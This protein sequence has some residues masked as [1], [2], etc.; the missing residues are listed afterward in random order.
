M[1][2]SILEYLEASASRSPDKAAFTDERGDITYAALLSLARS[3]GT[4]L[5]KRI[6]ARSPVAV[7]MDARDARCV[8][9]FLGAVYAG[10]FY[11]PLDPAAPADR[12]RLFLQTL[13]PAAMVYDH[14][15]AG[16]AGGLMDAA[17]DIVSYD[18]LSEREA[19]PS[20]LEDARKRASVFDTLTVLFTSGSTGAPKCVAH[21]HLAMINYTEITNEVFGFTEDT[22][23]GNQSPFFYANSIIDIYPPLALGASV[24]LLPASA[25]S[26]PKRF[27]E[28]LN[29]SRVTELTMTPSSYVHIAN[30]GAL[31]AGALPRL[32]SVIMSGEAAPWRQV[33][34]WMDAAN[35]AVFYNF[36]GSTEALPVAVYRIDRDFS[37]DEAIPVGRLYD[38]VHILFLDENGGEAPMGEPG[39]IYVSSPW[40]STGYYRDKAR[41]DAAFVNDPL[42]RGCAERFYRTGDFGRVNARGELVV[43]GRMDAQIKHWGYRMELG[44]VERALRGLHGWNDG[45]CLFDRRSGL[46]YCFWDGKLTE[47]DIVSGLKVKLPKHMLPDRYIHLESVPYNANSKIDRSALR[48]RVTAP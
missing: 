37:D 38:R 13:K 6:E 29:S 31:A 33:R 21:N 39:E 32:R 12:L 35:H 2:T 24:N 17:G 43:L 40:L 8:P 42:G 23:F 44:E 41:S 4:A 22:V 10:G 46:V 11:A 15:Y 48:S 3:I 7:L 14:K 9:A 45:C 19:A 26:F 1:V 34:Q 30:S 5:A 18:E 16:L 36:Y 47:R 27:V 28:R 20:I 25:S